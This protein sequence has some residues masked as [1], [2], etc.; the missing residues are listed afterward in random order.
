[1]ALVEVS[2]PG[3]KKVDSHI[4]GFTVNTDQPV[5]GGGENSAPSPFDLFLASLASC[6]GIYAL[7]F[8]QSKGLS[9]EGLK[10]E[11][12]GERNPDTGLIGKI[13]LDLTLPEGFPDKYKA[14]ILKS[15]ELCTV[16]K[17]LANPPSFDMN[18]I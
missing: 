16:K 17:H 1:M 13:T 10:L 6:A 18:L 15:M 7:G 3:G 14:A 9:T 11:M 8:C 4:K 2:F 5:A 12:D